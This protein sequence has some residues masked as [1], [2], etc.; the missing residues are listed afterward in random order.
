MTGLGYLFIM[1]LFAFTGRA[2]WIFVTIKERSVI[3]RILTATVP[4][5]FIVTLFRYLA[6][7]GELHLDHWA[8][9]RYAAAVAMSKGFRL[10]NGP[11]EGVITGWIYPPLSAIAYLP[12]T[13][14]RSPDAGL[15][16]GGLLSGLYFF[17]CQSMYLLLRACIPEG[18][19]GSGGG[20]PYLNA[21]FVLFCAFNVCEQII[22]KSII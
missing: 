7:N 9:V 16:A 15:Q 19:P 12:A 1:V 5:G 8:A 14:F 22:G 3:D 2:L 6:K 18:R 10:Y 4:I 21:A 11:T 20:R 13:I 17:S